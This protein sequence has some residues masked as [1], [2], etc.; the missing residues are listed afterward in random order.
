MAIARFK[1]LCVDA[2]DPV[3]LGRFWAQVLGLRWHLQE[4]GDGELRG[5]TPRHTIWVN[6]VPEAKTAKNRVHL[7]IYTRRLDDLTGLGSAVVTPET[8]DQP[9]TVMTDPEGG[10]YCAFARPEPPA[11][12]LHGLVV[13]AADPAALARWWAGIYGAPM[14]H[15]PRGHYTVHQVPDMPIL[16][17]DFNLVPEPKTVKN[18]VHWDVSVTDP[19]ALVDAGAIL[20]CPPTGAAYWHVM[21]DPE[22][23]EFCAFTD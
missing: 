9:W 16:T 10:E 1:D 7:D 5:P 3:R 19:Q 18:R 8:G 6:R 22:G 4:D 17:M 14:E 13:D 11:G 23:N 12:R 20:L 21:A 15:D 2:N